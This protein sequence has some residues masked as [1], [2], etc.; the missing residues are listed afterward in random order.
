MKRNVSITFLLFAVVMMVNVALAADFSIAIDGEKDA[1][2]EALTG[3]AEG[4]LVIPAAAYNTNGQPTDDADASAKF[5]AAWDESYLYFY[6]EV[7]DNVVNLNNATS[8]QNDILEMYFDPEPAAAFA[9]GQ[10]GIT[11][12]ALDSADVVDPTILPGV[13]NLTGNGQAAGI[14]GSKEDYARKKTADGYII[15]G[16]IKWDWTKATDGRNPI[17]PAAG[18]IFGLAIMNH[19][20]D[21]ATREGSITWATIM[22]DAVWNQPPMHGKVEFI[23][24]NKLKFSAENAI[25]GVKNPLAP[26]F[27][28]NNLPAPWLTMD[29]GAVAAAGSAEVVDGKVKVTGSGADIWDLKD[30][31]QFVFQTMTGDVEITANVEELTQSDPW[32]KGALMIRD[33]LND[34]SAHAIIALASANGE[35]FQ[36][37]PKAGEISVHIAGVTTVLPPKWIK[38]I[39]MGNVLSGYTSVDGVGWDFIG[40]ATVPMTNQV[41]VGMAVTSHSDGLLSTC[42]YSGVT[43]S[44]TPQAPMLNFDMV[45]DAVKDPWY[46]SITGPDNGYVV[47]P[48]AAYN[49]NGQPDNAADLSASMWTAW[50]ENYLYI[51]EEVKDNKVNVNNA[52]SWQ[53]DVFEM[54]FDPNPSGTVTNGQ[55]GITITALDTADVDAAAYAGITNLTG[56][57]SVK[58]DATKL[59]YARAKI[60][61]GYAIEARLKW[62]WIKDATRSLTPEVGKIFGMGVMNHDND[63]ATRE[64][65]ISWATVL[66]DAVW[67]TPANHGTVEILA[68]HQLKL[69]AKSSRDAALVNTLAP[70]YVPNALPADWLTMNLG[71]VAGEGSVTESAG[72]WTVAGAG[73][74]IWGKEDA[75]RYAFQVKSGDIEFTSKLESLTQSDPWTKAGLM[76]R[77]DLTPGAKNVFIAL[78]SKNGETFQYRT[79]TDG[80]SFNTAGVTTLKPPYFLKVV[81]LGD[82]FQGWTSADG[83]KGTWT[84]IGQ[85]EMPMTGQI[86]VGY[87]VTAHHATKTSTA[88]FSGPLWSAKPTAVEEDNN[89]ALPTAFELNQ[90]YPNPFNPTTTIEFSLPVDRKVKLTV[91]DVLGRE[92]AVLLD[93]R[94]TAGFHH[95]TFDGSQISSGV[96][97]YRLQAGDQMLTKKLLLVK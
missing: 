89:G 93:S 82:V 26:I 18:N 1:W 75:F 90:N 29:I 4:Y 74:D 63:V 52:T 36:Y 84:K 45:I 58:T 28:P 76:I 53:N 9:T 95:V 2:Y 34:S 44:N 3:N 43:V 38:L 96:Y 60:T 50:D 48:A 20:N 61:G 31:F 47:I 91:F 87:A 19:D 15:E 80:E 46:K 13:M 54:Y 79:E 23:A 10:I 8:Y 25:T 65:S 14:I 56:N 41:Y 32:T 78:A 73:A 97:F 94:M 42:T 33:A 7:K 30:E 22:D 39:R 37:R 35:A 51:Y 40:R 5:W 21:V 70:L 86:Y 57:G 59:D 83:K 88:V 55:V 69:T 12:S 49:N 66:E 67:G 64:G 17:T 11:I 6:E 62:G 85:V 24:D 27:E 77:D 72:T 71:T 92:V 68:N 16:R 81:R